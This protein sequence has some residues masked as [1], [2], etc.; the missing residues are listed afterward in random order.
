MDLVKWD[1][2]DPR[3]SLT[4]IQREMRDLFD[5]LSSGQQIE[6]YASIEFPPIIVST[7]EN[8]V[9]VRAEL[10]GIKVNDLDIQVV[11]DILT[12]RGERKPTVDRAKATYLR[13]ER[14]Y[15]TFARTIVLPE[16]VEMEK[17]AAS[18]KNGI[19]TVILPK[20]AESKPKQ[21]LI[22]KS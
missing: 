3:D 11:K 17:V 18:Y 22:K 6:G 16:N 2:N 12:I 7:S 10:P 20:S 8:N 13:R 15:G 1:R 19:L 4:H 5:F 9:I 21:V 14:N